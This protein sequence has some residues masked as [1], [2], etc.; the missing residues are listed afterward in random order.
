MYVGDTRLEAL[1]TYVVSG[2]DRLARKAIR[3]FDASRDASGLTQSRYPSRVRQVIPP[4]ALAWIGMLHDF[5]LWRGDIAFVRSVM[6]GVRAVIEAYLTYRNAEGLIQ[7]PATAWNYV[8]WVPTW[9]NGVPPDADAGVSS[10]INW[11]FVGALRQAQE[12]EEWLGEPDLAARCARLAQATAA[13]IDATFWEP[14]RG[15]YAD[16]RARRHFSEHAQCLAILSGVLSDDRVAQV[17]AGLLTSRELTRTTIYFS[18]YLFETLRHLATTG[19]RWPIDPIA[20]LFD[21]LSLWFDLRRQG[22]VTP[23]EEPDPSRSDCHG[24]GSH[25][26]FH[27]FATILGI[28]PAALGFTQVEVRP[29]L[30]PLIQTSGRIPH[31]AGGFIEVN[32]QLNDVH[33]TLPPGITRTVANPAPRK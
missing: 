20:T 24:W 29:H 22:F 3:L 25:P 27:Y 15:L 14:V 4:F 21:R 11:Q 28:R 16:G 7:G 1:V 18:H 5:A 10:V 6:P 23:F 2:D 19:K 9:K 33:L 17:G 13:A 8:D 12:L 31:P 26:L 30:G 32:A